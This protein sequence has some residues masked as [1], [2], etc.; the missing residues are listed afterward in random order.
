MV[1]HPSLTAN[2]KTVGWLPRDARQICGRAVTLLAVMTIRK[3]SRALSVISTKAEGRAEKSGPERALR[4][5]RGQ[6]SRLRYASLD[7]TN[8]ARFSE[9]R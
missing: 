8:G 9:S 7:M 5:I 4:Q 3:E 6:M 2:A 1:P